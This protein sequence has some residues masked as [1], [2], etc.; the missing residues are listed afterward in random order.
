MTF[1]TYLLNKLS[2]V[3]RNAIDNFKKKPAD[4][5]KK[6]L[7]TLLPHLAN[8]LYGQ[9]RNILPNDSYENFIKKI[10]VVTYDNLKPYIERMRKEEPN[11]LW[12]K[13][14]K[15]FAKSSG[16]T[17]DVSKYI[18]VP[19]ECLWKCHYQ[20]A[21]DVISIYLN[22]HPESRLFSGKTLTLGG[23][24][25][26]DTLSGTTI[27]TGDLSA[28]LIQNTPF[29]AAA[30]R[31]PETKTALIPDF[32]KKVAEI[33]RE[34]ADKNITSFA[35]VPSWN[36]VLLKSL[37]DYTGKQNICEVWPNME[38]FIHGG[39]AFSP[40]REQ[41]KKL[42]PSEKMNYMETYNASEGFFALQDNPDDEAMLLMLDYG[43]FYEFLDMKDLNNPEKTIPLEEVKCDTNYAVIISSNSG[44]WRYMIG[45]TVRFT[46][47]Y[48]HKIIITGRTKHYIN[49]FGEEVIIDNAQQALDEACKKTGASVTDFTVAPIY[50]DEK[51]QGAHQ[52]II[53]FGQ[54]PNDWDLFGTVLDE[55]LQNINS[56]YRAKRAPGSSLKQA[57]IT[58]APQG[59]FYQWMKERGKLGGQNKIPRLANDRKYADQLLEIIDR[60]N[61]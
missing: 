8:V 13:P 1:S 53:E 3:R 42:I 56:D 57:K 35:G 61:D 37:L 9:E 32:E 20:G 10:P 21:R 15:W 14:V 49:V 46:S 19:K 36:M 23:S 41:Y 4:V 44:L 34:T 5:Q 47:L 54:K 55:T 30:Y 38:L 33:C 22:N 59:T 26:L 43:V 40:Y 60:N 25:A 28:I 58:A 24:H 6:Q 7:K 39:V 52:W 31:A 16:T 45:D 12:D 18:P 11:I 29:Y 50:M 51:A 2:S 27:R 48:P 17:A